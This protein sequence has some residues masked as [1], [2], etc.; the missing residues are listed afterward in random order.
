MRLRDGL[1][2]NPG[3]AKVAGSGSP[4]IP[5]LDAPA[6]RESAALFASYEFS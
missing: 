3:E 4:G 1:K 6:M 2:K 5:A